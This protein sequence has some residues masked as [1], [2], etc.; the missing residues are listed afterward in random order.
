M[1]HCG[2]GKTTILNKICG[3]K[4]LAKVSKDSLTRGLALYDNSYGNNSFTI[5]DTPGDDSR[6]DVRKHA[7]LIK[8]SLTFIP[9]NAIFII[10][11]YQDR[12]DSMIEE[13]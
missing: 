7:L 1:G 4:R 13:F 10:V 12:V 11:K 5:V 9:L 2:V 6:K 8:H 3:T